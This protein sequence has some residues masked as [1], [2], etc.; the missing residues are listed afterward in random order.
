MSEEREEREERKIL[1][2]IKKAVYPY[3][4]VISVKIFIILWGILGIIF[5]FSHRFI[6]GGVLLLVSLIPFLSGIKTISE[7]KRWIIECFGKYYTTL[8]AGLHWICPIVEK[9]RTFV[10][11]WEQRYVLWKDREIKIDFKNGSAI[12]RKAIVY[13]QLNEEEDQD[14]AYRMVYKIKN[15]EEAVC[16]LV[17]NAARSYLNALTV[18]QGLEEGEAGY[19][20]FDGMMKRNR[21]KEKE[22]IDETIR[23]WGLRAIRL[24]VGDYDLDKTVI[25]SRENLLHQQYE[26]KAAPFEAEQ[27][28]R[29]TM[30]ADVDMVT[31]AIGKDPTKKEERFKY[32][33]KEAKKRAGDYIKR[34]MSIDGDALVDIH[35]EGK[36]G[37]FNPLNWIA[38]WKKIQEKPGTGK[39]EKD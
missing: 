33:K 36:E 24:T 14:A 17:E 16:T 30:G 37:G 2:P 10:S 34:R 26:A 9:R 23:G 1:P 7:E 18:E 6:S 32:S 8:K 21:E 39:K 12:P 29:E 15:V 20:L 31:I 13:V 38:T 11:A 19:N 27:R 3:P 4:V 22:K 5:L 35:T 25:E 28:A